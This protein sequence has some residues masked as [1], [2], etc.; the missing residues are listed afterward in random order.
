MT[1]FYAKQT[2][3]RYTPKGKKISIVKDNPYKKNSVL[4][5]EFGSD[6]FYSKTG[7]REKY[8]SDEEW[9]LAKLI[10]SGLSQSEVISAFMEQFGTHTEGSVSL[11]YR[12]AVNCATQGEKGMSHL[13]QSF[14]NKLASLDPETFG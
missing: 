8:T 12:Q 13:T 9:F 11:M 2:I 1:F 3:N 4:Y 14:M 6:A 5:R 7:S 10:V